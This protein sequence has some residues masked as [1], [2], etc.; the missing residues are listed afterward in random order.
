MI[1]ILHGHH[2]I[3]GVYVKL[4][5]MPTGT[6]HGILQKGKGKHQHEI[7][8]TS[9]AICDKRVE[10]SRDDPLLV[11]ISGPHLGTFVCRITH[12]YVDEKQ[13]GNDKWLVLAVVDKEKPVDKL[14]GVLIECGVDELAFVEESPTD[15]FRAT[16]GAMKRVRDD[17][18][19]QRKPEV[20]RPDTGNLDRFISIIHSQ[21][22]LD[23][24]GQST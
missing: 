18:R 8:L 24:A 17:A 4:A 10:L 22:S 15:R 9:L 5:R 2:K 7:P 1:D 3:A 11:V 6:I 14:T 13:T 16:H 21:L 12:F 20:R 19:L 23:S